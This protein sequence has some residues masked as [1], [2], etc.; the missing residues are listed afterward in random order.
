M[1]ASVQN[2]WVCVELTWYARCVTQSEGQYVR[3]RPGRVGMCSTHLV[4]ML[5]YVSQSEGQYVRLHPGCVCMCRTQCMHS[6]VG[7]K[8]TYSEVSTCASV[9]DAWACVQLSSAIC[10]CHE[11]QPAAQLCQCSAPP[12]RTCRNMFTSPTYI[13]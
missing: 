10:T 9:Q 2:A 13:L 4:C 8:V 7:H 3:L 6:T 11:S 5:C 1:C 12:S